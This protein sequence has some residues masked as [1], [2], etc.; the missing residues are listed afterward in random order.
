[1]ENSRRVRGGVHMRPESHRGTEWLPGRSTQEAAEMSR[2][3]SAH[4]VDS[5]ALVCCA[6][7]SRPCVRSY[8]SPFGE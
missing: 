4:C 3:N 6:R 1:V 5:R 7:G 8:D 2:C